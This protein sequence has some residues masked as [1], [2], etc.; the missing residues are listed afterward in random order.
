MDLDPLAQLAELTDFNVTT[1]AQHDLGFLDEMTLDRV[2]VIAKDK[3]PF[4]NTGIPVTR[5]GFT[6][7]GAELSDLADFAGWSGPNIAVFAPKATDLTPLAGSRPKMLILDS[8]ATD[9]TPVGQMKGLTHLWLTGPLTDLTPLADLTGLE[10]LGLSGAPAV[11]NLSPLAGLPALQEL[12]VSYTSVRDVSVAATMPSLT[13]LYLSNTRVSSLGPA[14]S[15][16][17]LTDV[18]AVESSLQ[19]IEALKGATGLAKVILRDAR[20][21]DISP[22]ADLP[23]G[24]LLDLENNQIHDFSSLAGWSGTLLARGQKVTLPDLVAEARYPIALLDEHGKPLRGDDRYQNGALYYTGPSEQLFFSN[25][26]AKATITVTLNQKVLQ[27]RKLTKTRTPTIVGG[28]KPKVGQKLSISMPKWTPAATSYTYTWYRD[29]HPVPGANGSTYTLTS[30]DYNEYIQVYVIGH[31]EGHQAATVH[32]AYTSYVGKG[33]FASTPAP[34]ITGTRKVGHKLTATVTWKPKPSSLTYQ[35]YR[36]GTKIKN[37]TKSTYKL[38]K[39]DRGKRITVKV[40]GKKR[41]YTTH[42]RA[43]AKT[44]KIA[45]A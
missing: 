22:L 34:K 5:S 2:K 13:T 14:G 17:G 33:H 45:K 8:A 18:R 41:G 15:L 12:N 3:R 9:L 6:V 39:T 38:T 44:A 40:T 36:N 37:A 28:K 24:A 43:S 27:G 42:T 32:S 1:T 10:N 21:T 23:N 26:P 30:A 25:A 35:W 20:V 31:R 16:S 19:N 11:S 4:R 29:G 7:S